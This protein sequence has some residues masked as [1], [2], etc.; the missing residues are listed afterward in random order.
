MQAA[1]KQVYVW[2]VNDALSMSAMLSSGVDGLITDEPALARQV[3]VARAEMNSA[4]RLLL[5]LS[6]SL[7]LRL[8]G[9]RDAVPVQ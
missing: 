7:G 1:G 8:G 6:H 3:L 9:E 5:W 4:E 2:T